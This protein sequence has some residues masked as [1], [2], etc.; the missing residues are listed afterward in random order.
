MFN[1]KPSTIYTGVGYFGSVT[2]KQS[3]RTSRNRRQ[4]KQYDLVFICLTTKGESWELAVELSTYH[5]NLALRQWIAE[6][7]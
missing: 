1:N 7:N 3:K 5:F 6:Q 2:V 4:C